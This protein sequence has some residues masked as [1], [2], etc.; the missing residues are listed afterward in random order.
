MKYL[1]SILLFCSLALVSCNKAEEAPATEDQH[2]E[3]TE[4]H[5]EHGEECDGHHDHKS[6][7]QENFEVKDESCCSESADGKCDSSCADTDKKD[8]VHKCDEDCTCTDTKDAD[9]KTAN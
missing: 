1:L 5:H 8:A 4:H 3:A 9:K 6:S 7:D 2:I